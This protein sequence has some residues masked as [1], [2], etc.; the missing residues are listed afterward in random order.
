MFDETVFK[1]IKD[2]K[3]CFFKK[4][5]PKIFSW[6]ELERLI[7]LRPMINNK[8]F[9]MTDCSTSYSW[10]RQG[11]LS[12]VNTFPPSLLDNE[13][14]QRYVCYVND[15][16]RVNPHTNLIASKI[17]KTFPDSVTDAHVYFSVGES[18]SEG[19]GIH[20]DYLYVLVIHVEGSSKIRI[21]DPSIT[22]EI[23]GGRIRVKELM[24][25][26]VIDE[27]METGDAAF[28]PINTYHCISS[29]TKRLSISF[30]IDMK[31]NLP[32]Q[33]R[34]WIKLKV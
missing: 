5:F 28:I 33:D 12:D 14:M 19:F 21:W 1:K 3:P 29:Q 22:E 7:N 26:P 16:S 17:E 23:G 15:C 4:A 8:R 30:P 34:H 2:L 20:M 24:Q 6:E 11:Y 13:I 18:L 31:S 9:V 27:I 25:S 32:P 10:M